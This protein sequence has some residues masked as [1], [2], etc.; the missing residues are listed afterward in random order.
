MRYVKHVNEKLARLYV[1]R[2]HFPVSRDAGDEPA[3]AQH[4]RHLE[5]LEQRKLRN[6]DPAVRKPR[7]QHVP[8]HSCN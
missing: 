2:V 3:E 7:K 5:H 1:T 4:A 6:A 8:L